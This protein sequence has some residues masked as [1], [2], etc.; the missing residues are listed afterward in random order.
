MTKFIY[1][2]KINSL[3]ISEVYRI[4]LINPEDVY[5]TIGESVRYKGREIQITDLVVY[6]EGY[7]GAM[8][9][10][11]LC[12]ILNNKRGSEK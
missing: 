8:T 1:I 10:G 7:E 6:R 4:E 5:I 12:V 2:K 11:V 3:D 9:D